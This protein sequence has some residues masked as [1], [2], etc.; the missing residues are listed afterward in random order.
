MR[1]TL[2][3][4]AA[5]AALSAGAAFPASASDV[6]LPDKI[7]YVAPAADVPDSFRKFIGRWEGRWG[8]ELDHIFIGEYRIRRNVTYSVLKK[9]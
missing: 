8:T 5:F 2:K 6:P 7:E 4:I 9:Q 1:G 3:A